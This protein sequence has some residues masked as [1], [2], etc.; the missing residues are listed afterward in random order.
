MMFRHVFAVAVS[1]LALLCSTATAQMIEYDLVNFPDYVVDPNDPSRPSRYKVQCPADA[2]CFLHTSSVSS[3]G[4]DPNDKFRDGSWKLGNGT[5]NGDNFMKWFYFLNGA[6]NPTV[7]T[8][9]Q[10]TS[11][12]AFISGDYCRENSTCSIICSDS[13][14][15]GVEWFP[16]VECAV[17]GEY[18]DTSLPEREDRIIYEYLQ[19][20]T[21]GSN[22]T[23]INGDGMTMQ[24]RCADFLNGCYIDQ[25]SFVGSQTSYANTTSYDGFFAIDY[26][27]CK[28]DEGANFPCR[29]G[30]DPDCTCTMVNRAD[31]TTSD[32]IMA[33]PTAAPTA[34]P[35]EA[36]TEAGATHLG[37]PLVGCAFGILAVMLVV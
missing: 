1:S 30:C 33:P 26:L 25:D 24:L 22:E 6:E 12:D 3:W 35:T 4:P 10:V 21:A 16:P 14:L 2:R 7:D 8:M 29:I 19:D 20:F 31:G 15:C 37:L 5:T 32:C 34:A 18:P 17:L 36:P 9:F 11:K 23:A 28:G 13:C 27:G